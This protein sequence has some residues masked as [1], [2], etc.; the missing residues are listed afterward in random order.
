MDDTPSELITNG[1]EGTVK[2]L[3]DLGQKIWEQKKWPTEWTKSLV[4]PLPKKG[5]LRQCQD[6][7]TISLTSHP[8]KVMQASEQDRVQFNRS[9]TADS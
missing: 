4:T 3:T 2:A 1:V 5:S 8:S 6:C 9:S 7:G